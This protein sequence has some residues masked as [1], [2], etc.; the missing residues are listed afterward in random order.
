MR[1]RSN[2]RRIRYPARHEDTRDERLELRLTEEEDVPTSRYIVMNAEYDLP[3]LEEYLHELREL[4][5]PT[6]H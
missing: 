6:I 1:T 5:S 3:A 4:G 2:D